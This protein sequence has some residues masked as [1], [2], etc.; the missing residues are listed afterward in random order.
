MIKPTYSLLQRVAIYDR[1]I[2][3][4][5]HVARELGDAADVTRFQVVRDLRWMRNELKAPIASSPLRYSRKFNCTVAVLKHL[6][7][8]TP[9]E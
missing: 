3:E 9:R 4:K 1:M 2:R 7:F 5:K 6:G 8:L